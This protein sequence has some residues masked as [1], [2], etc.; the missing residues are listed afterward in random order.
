MEQSSD[1]IYKYGKSLITNL[2]ILVRITGIYDSMNDTI[3]N[4]AGRLLGD[5][6]RFLEETGDFTVKVIEGSFYIEGTRIR[7]GVSD[8]ENF[9]ALAQTLM[10]KSIGV[11][12]FVSPVR[13]EDLVNL[14]YSIREGSEASEVQTRL[15]GKSTNNI[16]IGGPVLLLKEEGIDLKDGL[17]MARRT[18][19]KAVAAMMTMDASLKTGKRFKLKKVKRPLQLI[20]DSILYDESF[21]LR[22]AAA[23]NHDNYYYFHPVNVAVFSVAIGR[24]IGLDRV[25]LRTLAMAAFFHDAGKIGMPLSILGKETDFT[26]KEDELI[27]RHPTEGIKIFLKSFG[28]SETTIISMLVSYEHHMKLDLSGYPSVPDGRRLNLFS[29]IVSIADDFDSLVSGRVYGRNRVSREDALKLLIQKSGS[30]YDPPLVKALVDIF[31]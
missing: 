26:P 18:Y 12:D 1:K 23:R 31:I 9:T 24:R 6:G 8:I 29:R 5:I 22:F 25:Q 20:V 15:E 30:H 27:R 28:L 16:S 13:A 10:D 3:L 4:V 11:L 19:S 7:A 21:L 17:A 14:A 2:H